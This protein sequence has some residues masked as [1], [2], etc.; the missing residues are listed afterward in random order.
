[1]LFNFNFHDDGGQVVNR[2]FC[3]ADWYD[4][5][6]EKAEKAAKEVSAHAIQYCDAKG[7][8]ESVYALPHLVRWLRPDQMAPFGIPSGWKAVL[9]DCCVQQSG[10]CGVLVQ[11]EDTGLFAIYSQHCLSSVNQKFAR[12]A[13]NL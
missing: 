11:N 12:W 7:E 6:Y 1:M 8:P 5:A 13:A 4:E 9:T 3:I 10:N 2:F